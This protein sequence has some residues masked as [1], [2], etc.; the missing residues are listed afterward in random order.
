M[1]HPRV[2]DMVVY[3]DER[4]FPHNALLKA[5]WDG[6]DETNN[7][8]CVNLVYVSQDDRRQDDAGRQTEVKTS[9]VHKSMQAVHGFYWRWPEEEPNVGIAVSK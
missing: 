2:G 4:G 1:T 5:V 7:F 6:G 3:H 8:P 9:I